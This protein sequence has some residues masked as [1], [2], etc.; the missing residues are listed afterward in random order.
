MTR[1]ELIRKLATTGHLNVPE[2]AALGPAP[3]GRAEL[4]DVISEVVAEC[5]SFPPHA[6][7][8]T[9]GTACYEGRVIE[10]VG[11]SRFRLHLQRALPTNPMQLAQASHT[12][13]ASLESVVKAYVDAEISADIDGVIVD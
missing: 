2:R 8:W 3:V 1:H 9:P 4:F 6:R 5:G 12:D 7:P 13:F 11:P 10:T